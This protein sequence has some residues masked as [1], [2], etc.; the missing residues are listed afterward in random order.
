[1]KRLKWKARQRQICLFRKK[2]RRARKKRR[3]MLKTAATWKRYI[4]IK[5][6]DVFT[7]WREDARRKLL[8]FIRRL[9]TNSAVDNKWMCIDFSGTQKMIADGTLIFFAELS[10]LRR[11]IAGRR[12]RIRCIAPRNA[13]VAQVLMQVGIFKLLGF[14]KRIEP[15]FAD[16][17]HWRSA[18]GREVNGEK[19]DSV[20][21]NYEGRI[22]D[23]LG[24]KFFRGLTEAMTNCHHHAYIG[25]RPDGLNAMEE[26]REWWMFSQEKDGCLTVVFCDLGIGIPGSL[27]MKKPSLWQRVQATFGSNLDAHAIQEA[28]ADS[29]TRTGKHHRG[30]GLKQLIDV[31]SSSSDGR[32]NIFSNKGCFSLKSGK[33]DISQYKDSI[34]GTLIHWSVPIGDLSDD[35]VKN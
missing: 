2:M 17:I 8:R 26:P 27:P 4:K 16:V 25:I 20:L 19:Y 32:V 1:M 33:E 21:G 15:T 10:R 31:V 29:R 14:R 7:V 3:R 34:F 24:K 28:I 18:S 22:A 9:R 11:L 5:A 23:A 30:K 35:T 12:V 6:P 13:K